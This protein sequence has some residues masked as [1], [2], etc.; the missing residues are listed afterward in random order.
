MNKRFQKA[1]F[2]AILVNSVGYGA[3]L[4]GVSSIDLG[5][6]V[7]TCFSMVLGLGFMGCYEE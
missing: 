1:V 3:N 4:F 2:F 6:N 7:G 5:Q